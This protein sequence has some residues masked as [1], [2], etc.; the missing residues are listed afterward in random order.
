MPSPQAIHVI[1]ENA[2]WL[3]PLARAERDDFTRPDFGPAPDRRWSCVNRKCDQNRAR[4]D[5][6]KCDPR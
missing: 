2:A 5:C 3:E 1:H 4:R 6:D